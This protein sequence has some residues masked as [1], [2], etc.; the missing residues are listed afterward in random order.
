[1]KSEE[2]LIRISNLKDEVESRT[3]EIES[4]ERQLKKNNEREVR[5]LKRKT[6]RK[7]EKLARFIKHNSNRTLIVELDW[8]EIDDEGNIQ[9]NKAHYICKPGEYNLYKTSK[10]NIVIE[11][12]NV[13]WSLLECIDNIYVAFE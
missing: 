6:R 7:A 2:I 13:F 1:M 11:K 5:V 12:S 3:K 4:L 8:P 10:G 9:Y